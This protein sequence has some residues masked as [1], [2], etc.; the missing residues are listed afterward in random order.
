MYKVRFFL[1]FYDVELILNNSVKPL[2]F[3]VNFVYNWNLD[4]NY[5]Y[6]RL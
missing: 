2:Y 1:D 4:A 6:V 5:L 3:R